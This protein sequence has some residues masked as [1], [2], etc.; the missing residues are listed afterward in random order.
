M[1]R[2]GDCFLDGTKRNPLNVIFGFR[3]VVTSGKSGR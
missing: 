3:N 2:R 1:D